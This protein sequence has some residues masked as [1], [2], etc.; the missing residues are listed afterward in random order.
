MYVYKAIYSPLATYCA[1][2]F[3]LCICQIQLWDILFWRLDNT[4]MQL[5]LASFQW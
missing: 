1:D 4:K 5:L 3:D 2:G